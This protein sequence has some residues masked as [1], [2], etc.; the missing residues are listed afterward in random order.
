MTYRCR[1]APIIEVNGRSPTP[2]PMFRY[3][4]DPTAKGIIQAARRDRAGAA[5]IAA[6]PHQHGRSR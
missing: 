5:D 2:L 6:V 4:L 1:P 3:H